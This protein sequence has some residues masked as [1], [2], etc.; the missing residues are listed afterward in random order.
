MVLFLSKK[1]RIKKS[2]IGK[3][4]FAIKRIRRGSLIIDYFQG[5]G[6]FLCLHDYDRL[7]NNG[8]DYDIQIDDDLFFAPIS[9]KDLQDADY[10][11]HSC[12]P[13][14]GINGSFK[15]V[16]L[17]DIEPWEEITFDYAMS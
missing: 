8:F 7:Y 11:N 2:K 6:K 1:V 5:K 12:N 17:K 9:K 15:I 10:L 3:G 16:A 14:C 13:N 4:L